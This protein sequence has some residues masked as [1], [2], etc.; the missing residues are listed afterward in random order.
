MG[1]LVRSMQRYGLTGKIAVHYNLPDEQQSAVEKFLQVRS[2]PTY[3]L[4]DKEGNIA[5]RKAPRPNKS[6]DLLN[7]VYKLLEK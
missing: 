2:F 7:A 3:M 1:H 5:D 6:D 4:I